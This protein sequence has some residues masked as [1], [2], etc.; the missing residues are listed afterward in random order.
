[1]TLAAALTGVQRELPVAIGW[2]PQM[3]PAFERQVASINALPWGQGSGVGQELL[4]HCVQDAL[5]LLCWRRKGKVEPLAC[6]EE[7]SQLGQ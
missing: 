1:M 4:R 6:D 3:P 5:R 2:C 7:V